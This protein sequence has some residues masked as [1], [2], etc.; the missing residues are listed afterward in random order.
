MINIF[1]FFSIGIDRDRTIALRAAMTCCLQKEQG[2]YVCLGLKHVGSSPQFH[3][4]AACIQG[5]LGCR[6]SP[7]FLFLVLLE[8][9]ADLS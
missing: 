3:H 2:R 5:S 7:L 8:F 4:V 6:F 9:C 1:V